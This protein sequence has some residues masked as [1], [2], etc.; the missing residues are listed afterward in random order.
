MATSYTDYLTQ[1]GVNMPSYYRA[2]DSGVSQYNYYQDSISKAT[3]TNKFT[4]NLSDLLVLKNLNGN[5]DPFFLSALTNL[6]TSQNVDQGTQTLAQRELYQVN[7][8][9]QK[10]GLSAINAPGGLGFT[11]VAPTAPSSSYTVAAP[12]AFTAPEPQQPNYSGN[13]AQRQAQA[14][15]YQHA[16]DAWYAQKQTYTSAYNTWSTNRDT[17]LNV[18]LPQLTS[19]YNT[20]LSGYNQR[21]QAYDTIATA[22]DV[23]L[24]KTQA[25]ADQVSKQITDQR[26][27]DEQQR[28]YELLKYSLHGVSRLFAGRPENI[29]TPS[30]VITKSPTLGGTK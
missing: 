19:Q 7:Q 14:L 1:A 21:K 13:S 15:A 3:S 26:L 23:T 5:N 30:Q 8:S 11:E 10:S 18:T 4:N 6:A 9:R 25:G 22:S 29:L 28:K 16:W 2:S 20:N 12:A 17:Y 27:Q 24:G